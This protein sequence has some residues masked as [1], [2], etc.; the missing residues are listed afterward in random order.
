MEKI[1][2]LI[3]G[4]VTLAAALRSNRSRRA[5]AV[6]KIAL[7]V[8]FVL[9]GAL[10]NAVYL[11]TGADYG[12][13]AMPLTSGSFATPGTRWSHRAR[14]CSS[15]S[16]WSSRPPSAYSSFDADDRPRLG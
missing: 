15:V 14:A 7:G 12:S 3:L 9:A 16:W 11:L 6:G 13:F 4:A 2:W 1:A 10:V 8:L 5:L